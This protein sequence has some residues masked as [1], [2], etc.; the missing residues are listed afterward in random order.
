MSYL[1]T[2]DKPTKVDWSDFSTDTVDKLS[3]EDCVKGIDERGAELDILQESLYAAA[4]HSVLI[5]LQA[6]DTGGKDGVIGHVF[7]YINPQGCQV[8]SFKQPN[9][10]EAAHDFLWRAHRNS[11]VKGMIKIFN[12]SHYEDVL[13]TRVHDLVP[14]KVWRKRYD[15]IKTFEGLLTANHTIVLKFYLHISKEVQRE[16]LL[17]READPTKSWKLSSSD[18]KERAFWEKY[19]DA[20]AEAIGK[21]GVKDAPWYVVPSNNK[22]YRNHAIADK[23][24]DVLRK[25][26]PEWDATLAR[27]GEQRK[28]D[29]FQARSLNPAMAAEALHEGEVLG[30]KPKTKKK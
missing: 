4:S 27:T 23:L 25:Y 16:R 26:K 20:Y 19:N 18:W 10:V 21:T 9:P 1:Y 11:P 2:I 29:L 15:E 30:I 8:T 14:E 24:A 6:M 5:V 28:H 13:V 3:K 17:S 7:K 12:R 22:S